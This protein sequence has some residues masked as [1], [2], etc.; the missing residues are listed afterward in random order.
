VLFDATHRLVPSFTSQDLAVFLYGLSD[1]K[2]IRWISS[3]AASE[4]PLTSSSA[5]GSSSSSGS[6]SLSDYPPLSVAKYD[7][8]LPLFVCEIL[9]KAMENGLSSS[10][11]CSTHDLS[12]WIYRYAIFSF[13]A[14][15][16]MVCFNV[17]QFGKS[18]S[19]LEESLTIFTTRFREEN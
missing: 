14:F 3:N 11:D 16:N 1:M 5:P 8:D 6:S 19:K 4:F 9:L 10:A 13:V 17:S 2:N 15:L 18:W 7:K 12:Q